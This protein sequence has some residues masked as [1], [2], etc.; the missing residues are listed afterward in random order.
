MRRAAAPTAQILFHSI[1]L[2]YEVTEAQEFQ[3]CQ[4]KD[5]PED[6]PEFGQRV[7][8]FPRGAAHEEEDDHKLEQK[9]NGGQDE[10]RSVFVHIIDDILFGQI[11]LFFG[12]FAHVFHQVFPFGAS[13]QSDCLSVL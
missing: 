12:E 5:N 13:F 10:P 8:F 3:D 9:G 7:P 11:E 4:Q 1:L 2:E 6:D